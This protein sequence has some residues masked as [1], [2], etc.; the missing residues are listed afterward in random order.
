M[1]QLSETVFDAFRTLSVGIRVRAAT[2]AN[3][4]IATALNPGDT[5]DGVTLAEGD[6]VLVKDQSTASQNGIYIVAAIP[7]RHIDYSSRA[8]DAA[9]AYNRHPGALFVVMEGTTNADTTWLCTSNRGAGD[10]DSTSLAF[11]L[12]LPAVGAQP[13]DAYL[14]TLAGLGLTLI[15]FKVWTASDTYTPTT[16][17]TAA[18]L[19]TLGGG[20]GGGGCGNSSAGGQSYAGGGGA[21]SLSLKRVTAADIGTSKA[22][23]IGAGGA[24]GA[25]G[26]NAGTAGGD[27]SIGSLCVGKGGTGGSAVA[28]A[29][30]GSG[31]GGA[32][33][34]AGTGDITG[35]GE[36]GEAGSGNGTIVTLLGRS[37]RGGNTFLGSG[38]TP[39]TVQGGGNAATGYGAGGSGGASR[40]NNGTAAGGNGSNGI[41]FV[42]EFA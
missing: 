38:G 30:T 24:G 15:G 35:T 25:A 13:L 1:R 41:A 19:G 2:T 4:T 23:T 12:M 7:V 28:G 6:M 21:G 39:Q 29:T 32:G 8:R 42:L 16:G 20:G 3:I 10:L 36:N 17:M 11:T 26:N 31:A 37:G 9:A 27:T 33:G 22:V 40:N 34:V 18:L 14:T 5:L